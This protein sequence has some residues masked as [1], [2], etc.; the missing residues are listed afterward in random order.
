MRRKLDRTQAGAIAPRLA[1]VGALIG[2][3]LVAAPHF[4][5]THATAVHSLA[6]SD[7]PNSRVDAANSGVEANRTGPISGVTQ[8]YSGADAIGGSL[9]GAQLDAA[10]NL[11]FGKSLGTVYSYKI[12]AA[13]GALTQNWSSTVGATGGN[14]NGTVSSVTLSSDGGAYVGDDSGKVWQINVPAAAAGTAP[15]APIFTS[16]ARMEMTPNFDSNNHL[17]IGDDG[18]TFYSL[19]PPALGSGTT[20]SPNFSFAASGSTQAAG[21]TYAGTVS[22]APFSFF[23]EAAVDPSNNIYV[24]SSDTNPALSSQTLGTLYALSPAGAVLWKAPL[25]GAVINAVIYDGKV[26]PAEVI[27]ADKGQEVAA[28]NATTG[29]VIW[30]KLF[31]GAFQ[32]SPALS[33]DGKTVYAQDTSA[34]LLALNATTGATIFTA[35]VQGT[36]NSP[37]VDSQ[38]NIYVVDGGGK[39]NLVTNSG[40][41]SVLISGGTAAGQSGGVTGPKGSLVVSPDGTL[42]FSSGQGRLRGFS[43]S[44]PPTS[45]ATNT[46]VPPTSTS[47]NT[48][49]PTSTSTNTPTNTAT[50]TSTNTPVP[51]STATNTATATSTPNATATAA[52]AATLTAVAAAGVAPNCQLDVLPNPE[53]IQIGGS[54]AILFKAMPGAVITASILGGTYPITATLYN[55]TPTTPGTTV[56]G[57][58]VATP[59]PGGYQYTITV[60]PSGRAL[61]DF[62]VPTGATLGKVTVNVT[63]TKTGCRANGGALARTAIFTVEPA[64]ASSFTQSLH[65]FPKHGLIRSVQ[66]APAKGSIFTDKLRVVTAPNINV[67]LVVTTGKSTNPHTSGLEPA[68]VVGTVIYTGNVNSN[69]KGIATFTFPVTST[70]LIPG[71]G[72][73]IVKTVTMQAP[74]ASTT[75]TLKTS[76]AIREVRLRLLVQNEET[77]RGNK[78]AAFVIGKP[79]GTVT[80]STFTARVLADA[81]ASVSG[82]LTIGG[83]TLTAGPK[84]AGTGGRTSLKFA[85]P[86]A[87]TPKSGTASVSVTSTYRGA[88]ITRTINFHYNTKK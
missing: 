12:P 75:S 2:A 20:V 74:G 79:H 28:F 18:G 37:I 68:Y 27:V 13:P 36:A 80:T 24:A 5:A 70:V 39:I 61:L 83:S 10:G 7:K 40:T 69:A 9:T 35:P 66:P 59:A 3:T 51:T 8:T 86:D 23:G 21:T 67:G 33:P 44:L 42:F 54:E 56:T 71:Q 63:A 29:A 73:I 34:N 77:T 11:V 30:D 26:S 60:G 64:Q 46:P 84:A 81:G 78:R 48:P 17:L 76:A 88:T 45:T 25:Q 58:A 85:V 47:T 15:A 16:A 43:G 32:A 14:P 19:T 87:T 38:G 57:T 50:S 65:E 49:G 4:V 53:T 41:A 52:A 62:P 72:A 22:S 82:T 6:A 55:G 1:A 31:S